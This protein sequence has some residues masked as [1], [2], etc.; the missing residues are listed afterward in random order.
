MNKL[1]G[2]IE[3][4]L[5]VITTS[6]DRDL[7][8]SRDQNGP[9]LQFVLIDPSSCNVNNAPDQRKGS[10]WHKMSQPD[11]NS[12][13]QGK[14]AARDELTDSQSRHVS[15]QCSQCERIPSI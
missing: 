4:F 14:A 6:E 3:F 13:H 8:S 1:T 10:S 12:G 5:A 2:L 9:K 11:I 15:G 7:H